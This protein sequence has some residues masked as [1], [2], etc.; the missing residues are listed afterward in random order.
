MWR[1]Q[2]CYHKRLGAYTI[3][4]CNDAYS[5]TTL[6]PRDYAAGANSRVL[7]VLPPIVPASIHLMANR[8]L[9]LTDSVAYQRID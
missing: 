5:T 7:T 6:A 1:S 4:R 8:L 9:I 3:P 2:A